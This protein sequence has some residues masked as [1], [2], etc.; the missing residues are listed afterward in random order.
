MSQK[1]ILYSFRL[2]IIIEYL[3]TTAMRKRWVCV[4]GRIQ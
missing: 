3:I 4:G 2:I 1:A